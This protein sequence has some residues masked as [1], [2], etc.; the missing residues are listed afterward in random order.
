VRQHNVTGKERSGIRGPQTATA[1][2][3]VEGNGAQTGDKINE[4]MESREEVREGIVIV[5]QSGEVARY[6]IWRAKPKEAAHR[7]RFYGPTQKFQGKVA[8]E[9]GGF[10]RRFKPPFS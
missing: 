5:A 8:A 7:S 2:T 4:K 1:V 3:G 9:T 6:R 10:R